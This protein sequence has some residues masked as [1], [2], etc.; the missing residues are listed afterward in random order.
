MDTDTVF[1]KFKRN[2]KYYTS[3][4]LIQT[5]AERLMNFDHETELMKAIRSNSVKQLKTLL[6]QQIIE[7][8]KSVMDN[9]NLSM[10][11]LAVSLKRREVTKLLLAWNADVNFQDDFKVTPVMKAIAV[12]DN[13]TL[14][15]LLERPVDLSLKDDIGRTAFDYAE[16]FE[17]R[18][19]F[20]MLKQRIDNPKQ[21]SQ[22]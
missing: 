5:D 16:F 8:N 14:E 7:V 11:C 1:E 21:N 12:K 9:L 22:E 20:K 10:L 3:K 15:L 13:D 2:A 6:E 19:A 18:K 17:N 4:F